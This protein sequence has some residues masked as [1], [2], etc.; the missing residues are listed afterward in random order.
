MKSFLL[1]LWLTVLIGCTSTDSLM[2]DKTKRKPTASPTMY[3][4]P[5]KV[6][7]P[8]KTIGSLQMVGA[9]EDEFKAIKYF[10]K[11]AGRLGADG[12]ILDYDKAGYQ[13]W[14]GFAPTIAVDYKCHLIVYEK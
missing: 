12:F 5:S 6:T 1:I 14:V 11:E 13:K 7:V 3:S 10:T 2:T 4:D 9:K 8:Y